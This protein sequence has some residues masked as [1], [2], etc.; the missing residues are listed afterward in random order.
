MLRRLTLEVVLVTAA[1][2]VACSCSPSPASSEEPGPSATDGGISGD[3]R[4][5]EDA[6]PA[7]SEPGVYRVSGLALSLPT[8]DLA[9]LS[10]IIGKAEIIG[11]GESNHSSAGLYRAKSRLLRRLIE[12]E[13]VRVVAIEANWYASQAIDNALV[14]CPSNVDAVVTSGAI[15]P[16]RAYV[17]REISDLLT[18]ICQWNT[19][20]PTDRVHF[21]GV[22]V[23]QPWE[24][25]PRLR[26]F[27][28]SVDAAATGTLRDDLLACV[29]RSATTYSQYVALFSGGA[30]H[31]L[32]NHDRCISALDATDKLFASSR[33]VWEAASSPA[34]VETARLHARSLRAVEDQVSLYP[35]NVDGIVGASLHASMEARAIGLANVVQGLLPLKFPRARAALWMASLHMQ[36]ALSSATGPAQAGAT[37]LGTLLRRSLGDRYRAIAVTARTSQFRMP[38][39]ELG[40]L[41][42]RRGS[43]EDSLLS[44]LGAG[45][46]L[47]DITQ[48][49]RIVP[50]KVYELG[51]FSEVVADQFHGLVLMEES[52]A[53][54]YLPL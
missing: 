42:A 31:E 33:G 14:S 17:T 49:R 35:G 54:E 11:L 47:V 44:S 4:A 8:S 13:N 16:E 24:D 6:D 18:F 30:K 19:A 1:M 29:P 36:Y 53:A 50:S 10:A 38:N 5:A 20:H 21:L 12:A 9:P 3:A 23:R 27:L 46:W 25:S 45:P 40:D 28:E 39:G 41:N 22:D 32:G 15:G 2:I 37:D 34:A 43:I 26:A 51:G 7:P 52:P 48:T